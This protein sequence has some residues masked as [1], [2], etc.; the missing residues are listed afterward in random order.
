MDQGRFDDS[1]SPDEDFDTPGDKHKSG[2]VPVARREAVTSA[3][4]E[5]DSVE[6]DVNRA[7]TT[8]PPDRVLYTILAL[9]RQ[10]SVDM[11]R[12]DIVH[13][14]LDALRQLFPGRLL[15]V[16]LVKAS[17]SLALAHGTGRLR[18]G[19]RAQVELTREA[20]ERHGYAPDTVSHPGIILADNY[21]PVF[22]EAGKGFDVPMID[23]GRVIGTLGV[24]YMPNVQ[25][26]PDDRAVLGQIALQLGASLRNAR[27]LRESR[28]LKDYLTKL[29]DHA[30]APIAML[31][32]RRD[33]RVINQALL[34]LTGLSRDDV[35]G[36]DFLELLPESERNNLLPVF[37]NALRGKPVTNFEL[38]LPRIDGTMARVSVNVASIL[39]PEG[40]VEGVIAI[41]R[42]RTEVKELQQ[43]VIHAEKLATL[44]QL[45]AG[46]VHEL[47]N[48]LTSISAYGEYLHK[49]NESTGG[50]EGD[51]E[52]LRRIVEG[53]E[54]ILRFTRDLVTYA[55]PSPEKPRVVT[56][57]QVL[58]QAVV[59]CEHVI[60]EVGASV[61]KSYTE[62]LPPIYGVEG[63]LHQV[64]INLITNACH[65]MPQGAGRL[66]VETAPDGEDHLEV[67][68]TDNGRGIPEDQVEKIFEPFFSTK[69]EGKGT[70]LGLSI[71]RN[72]VEQHGGGISVQ[73]QVGGGTTFAVRLPCK[74]A[75]NP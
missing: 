1:A 30:N 54:R 14:Y 32:R 22:E 28:Y 24:E 73:S 23:N 49:K 45:A 46:V 40:E 72:I 19:R 38:S 36:K 17:G 5:R 34:G 51:R 48:P 59:F 39:S 16:R 15:L 7:L 43:Q 61:D 12:E 42:D 50:D 44:G 8:P 13:A 11:Q 9:S 25:E 18:E 10:I 75:V 60:A 27:L 70:G 65:A 37:I 55:R 52:K 31:G 29:V 20:L 71:V 35:I 4:L 21:R 41:G 2:R 68:I 56:I 33:I 67:R 6:R 47:N 64:F 26:P 69:G 74:P 53:A 58:D 62:D 57:E 3:T 66:M 63:Q